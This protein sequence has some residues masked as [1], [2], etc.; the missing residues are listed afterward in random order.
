MLDLLKALDAPRGISGRETAVASVVKNYFSKFCDSVSTDNLGSVYGVKHCAKEGA[1]T[2]MFEA[3]LDEIGMVVSGF[4]KEGSLRFI[5]I[6]GIDAKILPGMCVTVHS[7]SGDIFGVIGAK[8]PHL[9]T[10]R[11]KAPLISDMAVD[12]GYS[13][14]K[15]RSLVCVGDTISVNATFEKLCGTCAAGRCFDDRASIA[16]IIKALEIMQSYNITCHIHAVAAVQEEVGLRGAAVAAANI[17]PDAAIAIDVCHGKSAGVDE[18]AFEC[19]KGIVVSV[20]P[21]LHP[22]LTKKLLDTAAAERLDVQL[23]ADGGNTGT[24]AW[25]IQV[26]KTGIPVALLSVP[27]RYMHSNY[28]VCDTRDLESAARL[29]AQTALSFKGGEELCF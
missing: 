29:L 8:P 9:V 15:T 23:D 5:P 13:E 26:A 3:H 12:I 2:L 28:E 16:V 1:P 10:D 18:G 24:D 22:R 7:Q 27:L 11:S 4:T 21:N 19:G 20:G 14:E 17:M 6:G 25:E